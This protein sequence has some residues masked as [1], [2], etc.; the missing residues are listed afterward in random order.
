M[1][2]LN[3]D[4]LM[5]TDNGSYKCVVGE[6]NEKNISKSFLLKVEGKFMHNKQN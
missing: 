5:I 6:K 1:Y 2:V 4:A 3:F